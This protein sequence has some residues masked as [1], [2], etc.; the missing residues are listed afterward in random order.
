MCLCHCKRLWAANFL[1][2]IIDISWSMCLLVSV[3]NKI[4]LLILRFIFLGLLSCDKKLAVSVTVLVLFTELS[5]MPMVWWWNSRVPFS[6]D[7][8]IVHHVCGLQRNTLKLKKFNNFMIELEGAHLSTHKVYQ[9]KIQFLLFFLW[10]YWKMETGK[11]N[12]HEILLLL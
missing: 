4:G 7:M 2:V 8:H 12:F 3:C 9:Y 6:V 5:S 1:D 11:H 10:P